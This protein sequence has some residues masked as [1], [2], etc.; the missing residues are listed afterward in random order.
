MRADVVID[1]ADRTILPGLVNAHYHSHDALLKGCF[2]TIPRETWLLNALLQI[3]SRE[4][5]RN[6]GRGLCSARSGA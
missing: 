2:E 6:C 5:W 3:T 1:A 4:A